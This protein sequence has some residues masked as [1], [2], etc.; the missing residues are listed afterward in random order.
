[1]MK[2]QIILNSNQCNINWVIT[3]DQWKLNTKSHLQENIEIPE[4]RSHEGFHSTFFNVT[5]GVQSSDDPINN[6][7]VH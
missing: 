7:V 3:R 1:M 6:I 4:W 5:S 2:L